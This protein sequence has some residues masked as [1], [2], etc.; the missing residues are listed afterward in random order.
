MTNKITGKEPIGE[1]VQKY[2]Q[3]AE[4]FMKHG[5]HCLGC[6]ASHFENIEQG[7]EA[8]GLDVKKLIEDLNKSVAQTTKESDS[9]PEKTKK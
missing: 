5:M 4:V 8:H 2:P 3:T 7:A 1:I 9:S 6:A